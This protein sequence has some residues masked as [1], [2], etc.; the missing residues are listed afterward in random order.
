MKY[1]HG[2]LKFGWNQ[3]KLSTWQSLRHS[4]SIMHGVVF[5]MGQKFGNQPEMA[6]YGVSNSLYWWS[7]IASDC[8][9]T[10]VSKMSQS[11]VLVKQLIGSGHMCKII[12]GQSIVVTNR[13]LE[14]H[15]VVHH[16]F[17]TLQY[18]YYSCVNITLFSWGGG[19][20]S[21]GLTPNPMYSSI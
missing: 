10:V 17:I 20:G 2:W 11:L 1:C 6:T 19:L 3:V 7:P 13:L 21:V 12:L 4:K 8:W 16:N 14:L 5:E 9:C 15:L 18:I